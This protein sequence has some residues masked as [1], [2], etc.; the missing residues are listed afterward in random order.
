MGFG[1]GPP[2]G[3]PKPIGCAELQP[4]RRRATIQGR[5]SPWRTSRSCR[6]CRWCA[7]HTQV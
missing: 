3:A 4:L 5:V 2:L 1:S 7:L 6:T